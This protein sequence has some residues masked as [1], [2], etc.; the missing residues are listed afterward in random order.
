M[1]SG[2]YFV[3]PAVAA[4]F[5]L[6][7]AAQSAAA[8]DLEKGWDRFKLQVS[9]FRPDIN[10]DVRLDPVTGPFG[11]SLDLEN[12]LGLPDS[13]DLWQADVRFR[14]TKRFAL[15][16]SYFEIGRSGQSTLT[17]NVDFG[18]VSFPFSADT[19]S[20]FN[21]DIFAGSLRY[22][23]VHNDR[24]ELAASLGAYWMSVE[25]GIAAPNL[26]LEEIAEVD[27]PLPFIGMDFTLNFTRTL[28]LNLQGRYFG[29]EIEDID[30][31]LVNYNVAL[32]YNAFE[33]FGVGA[34]YESF[35]FDIESQNVDFPGF[36]RFEYEGP[37]IFT[38]FRF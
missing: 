30:G 25:A 19:D 35:D 32:V 4:V 6:A 9:M 36:L 27:A 5:L 12:D 37:K 34:G 7:G 23:L 8:A 38:T 11:T 22:S 3:T 20:E 1:G 21:T 24:A 14:L 17:G 15:E 10:T 26:A 18:D 16:A 31:S 29:I 2:K 28:A 13:D 33:H